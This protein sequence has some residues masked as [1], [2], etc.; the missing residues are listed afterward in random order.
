MDYEIKNIEM[1]DE[2][3]VLDIG[4]TVWQNLALRAVGDF[5]GLNN[6]FQIGLKTHVS[7]LPK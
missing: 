4:F 6:A 2:F 5:L 1:E 7:N 3:D